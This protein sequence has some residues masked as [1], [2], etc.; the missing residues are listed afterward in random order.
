MLQELRKRRSAAI[1]GWDYPL[2]TFIYLGFDCGLGVTGKISGAK[3]KPAESEQFSNQL[4][5]IERVQKAGRPQLSDL[6]WCVNDFTICGITQCEHDS[7][8][9]TRVSSSICFSYSTRE[10]HQLSCARLGSCDPTCNL[11]CPS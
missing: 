1:Y 4:S 8:N 7:Q 9:P 5:S 10:K 6:H 3:L 11:T 2:L